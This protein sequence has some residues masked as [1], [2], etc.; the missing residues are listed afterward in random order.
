MI[1]INQEDL[2]ELTKYYDYKPTHE[3]VEMMVDD[4]A[5]IIGKASGQEIEI[6]Q[7]FDDENYYRLYAGCSAVEVYILDG[8]I[9]VDFDIGYQ[10]APQS[11]SYYQSDQLVDTK[12]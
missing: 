11:M 6:I 1:T 3:I 10:L 12:Y 4:V 2:N 5:Q 7:D 8:V 9:Q